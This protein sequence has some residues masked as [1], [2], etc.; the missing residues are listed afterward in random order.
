MTQAAE[1]VRDS[2]RSFARGC[3]SGKPLL[4]LPTG[5]RVVVLLWVLVGAIGLLFYHKIPIVRN[6]LVYARTCYNLIDLGPSFSSA[7]HAYNKALGFPVLSLPMVIAFGANAGLKLSSFLWTALWVAS[8]IPF[9]RRLETTFN[10]NPEKRS[11]SML[12]AVVFVLNPL[13]YYQF[14]SAY[15]DSLHALVFLWALYFLDRGLSREVRWFDSA[16]FVMLVLLAIWVKHHGFVLFAI[17][18][19]FLICRARTLK[20]Q[21]KHSRHA[22]LVGAVS[23]AALLIVV[24]LAQ[25]GS[26]PFFNLS[27]N[28]ENYTRGWQHI[29]SQVSSNK[30]GIGFYLWLSFSVLTP[31]LLRLRGFRKHFE[32]YLALLVFVL[33][34]LPFRGT[35]DNLRYFLPIAPLIAW[36]TCLALSS[37]N[38]KLQVVLIALFLVLNSTTTLYYNSIPVHDWIARVRPL[39]IHDNLRLVRAQRNA[40]EFVRTV[41]HYVVSDDCHTLFFASRYYGDAEW[42]VYEREGLFDRRLDIVYSRNLEWQEIMRYSTEH[43]ITSALVYARRKGPLHDV[44]ENIWIRYVGYDVTLIKSRLQKH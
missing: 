42:H 30:K 4:S 35:R 31:V 19:V 5:P 16:V 10:P 43:G 41:N 21:W 28:T 25:T 24:W 6:S 29:V 1:V 32:W 33:T 2:N 3:A 12:P 26:I 20:W 9:F 27:R 36:I 8:A 7:K 37:L 15:S 39:K 17:L 44:P 38:R 11:D 14:L 34:L 23:L 40:D 22:V 18:P 13:V